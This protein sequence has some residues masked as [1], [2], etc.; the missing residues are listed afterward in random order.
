[1]K[2]TDFALH[3]KSYLTHYLPMQRNA[4][5]HTISG[6]RYA[7]IIL[8]RY[9]EH[10]CNLSL[11]KLKIEDIDT[12][13]ILNFLD[14]LIVDNHVSASTRNHRLAVLR[15]FFG[16]LQTQAPE[17]WSQCQRVLAIPL[18]R[19]SQ[20]EPTYLSTE[21]LAVLLDQPDRSTKIGRRD[22][23]LLSLLY[24]TGARVQELIELRVE[25]VHLAV[26]A[27]VRLTGKG[28][29]TRL[30]PLM[31]A[32]TAALGNYLDELRESVTVIGS[33]LVFSSQ[34]GGAFSR[35]GIRHLIKRYSDSARVICTDFPANVTPHCMR[36]TKA[37]HLLQ[38]G[39]PSIVIRDI[40][41]HADIKS[42]D[43]YARADM[44]MKRRALEK[45]PQLIDSPV[46][47][48][49]QKEPDLMD[50]LSSL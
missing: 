31:P 7:F 15:S 14:H 30:V 8:L 9:C 29:K 11:Q 4:S 28:R 45:S 37:M 25:A 41:G 39:N 22:A 40:L 47:R 1:M 34:R 49:W 19:V 26:P 2:S 23:M 36:H 38:A 16:Y 17:H 35:W 42:T 44:E 3:L 12:A 32:T 20:T 33:T 5:D 46:E 50:W 6:Y 13:L 43:V 48:S 27:R 18:Q 10:N 21:A 24:D